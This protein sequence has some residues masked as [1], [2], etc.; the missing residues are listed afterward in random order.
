[1]A[2]V[3]LQ[4]F[5]LLARR[6]LFVGSCPLTPITIWLLQHTLQLD[7]TRRLH[8][9]LSSSQHKNNVRYTTIQRLCILGLYRRYRN[10][11]LLLLLL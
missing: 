9:V 2:A 5:E 10:A 1:M 11:V 3:L 4:L 7:A 6:I 8:I